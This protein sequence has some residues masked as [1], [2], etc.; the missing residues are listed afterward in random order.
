[1][2]KLKPL[3]EKLNDNKHCV[4]RK[5]SKYLSVED[6]KIVELHAEEIIELSKENPYESLSIAYFGDNVPV[7]IMYMG[8]DSLSMK[9]TVD[10]L[11]IPNFP[12][13]NKGEVVFYLFRQKLKKATKNLPM[14]LEQLVAPGFEENLLLILKKFVRV[15]NGKKIDSEFYRDFK[16]L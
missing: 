2:G 8:Y 6:S 15:Y 4:Y 3:F 13:D 1:M 10:S 12:P 16:R 7:R 11:R 5:A 14:S 9:Q